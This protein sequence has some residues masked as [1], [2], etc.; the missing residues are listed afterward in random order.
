MISTVFNGAAY[1][2]VTGYLAVSFYKE[3]V[4]GPTY[5]LVY[6]ADLGAIALNFCISTVILQGHQREARSERRSNLSLTGDNS[7][8]HSSSSRVIATEVTTYGASPVTCPTHCHNALPSQIQ[9]PKCY[10]ID[11]DDT[12]AADD[13]EL[14][15]DISDDASDT[16]HEHLDDS[17]SPSQSLKEPILVTEHQTTSDVSLPGP[18][19]ELPLDTTPPASNLLPLPPTELQHQKSRRGKINSGIKRKY[20]PR[21]SR[22]I[23]ARNSVVCPRLRR[24]TNTIRES[25]NP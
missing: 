23:A 12:L 4:V 17:H 21:A 14:V 13:D 24:Q 15:K 7:S 18:D 3:A 16:Q 10:S 6:E 5:Q 20:E 25:F 1:L 19:V 22:L 8:S 9:K 11:S 2:A